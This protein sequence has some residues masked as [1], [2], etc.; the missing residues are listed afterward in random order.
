MRR[1]LLLLGCALL[2]M[3]APARASTPENAAPPAADRITVTVSG[4]GPDVI[5]IPGIASSARVWDATVAHLAP[6][7]RVHVVQVAG[8]G[9]VPAGANASGPVLEPVVDALHDYIVAQHLQGAA[10]IGHALGGT[11][12]LRLA[13]AHPGDAG[14]AMLVD[15]LPYLG[16]MFGARMNVALVRPQAARLRDQ[17]VRGTQED[18]AAGERVQMAQLI[19][20]HSAEADAA[21]A[22]AAASDHRVVGQALYDDMTLDLRSDLPRIAIPVTILYPWDETSGMPQEMF[23]ALYTDAFATLPHGKVERIDDSY[24]FI[25][26]DQPAIFLQ[27]VDLFLAS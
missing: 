8:F 19:K 23:D 25:M 2:L 16:M 27:K 10:V 26:I 12:A 22:A 24:Q 5:L 13:V 7:H 21:Y 15:A 14:R 6:T 20:A 1:F 4:Q 9:G 3:A 18:F 17:L 11:I